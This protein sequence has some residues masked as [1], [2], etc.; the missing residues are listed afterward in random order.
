MPFSLKSLIAC[1]MQA[2]AEHKIQKKE[3][4]KMCF[5]AHINKDGIVQ[6]VAQH[7]GNTARI[8]GNSLRRLGL[9]DSA[10]LAGLLHDAG[11]CTENFREY[12]EKVSRGEDVRRGSVIHTFAAVR[13]L[14]KTYHCPP[15]SEIEARDVTAEILSSAIGG[16]HGLFDCFDGNGIC[17]FIHRINKQPEDDDRAMEGFFREISDRSEVD[18]LFA[19]SI[20]EI[21]SKIR[22]IGSV[23]EKDDEQLFYLSLL[24]RL[25]TS[26]LIDADRSD[27]A[28]F[29]NPD[30]YSEGRCLTP[31]MLKR[32]TEHF[33]SRLSEFECVTPIQTARSELSGLCF[34]AASE[35]GGVLMLNL[36]T[37]AGKTLS[38]L[39]YALRHAEAFGKERIFFIS[40]L[41]SILEQNAL[42]IRKA[43]GDDTI[44]LEHHS[45]IVTGE[46]S[47]DELNRYELLCD[48][49][50]SP[51]VITTL[52]QFLRTLFSGKMSS[53]RRFHSLANSIIV[54]DEVQTVPL[55]MLSLFNSAV[56][57]LSA[58]C[59]ATVILCSA[60]QPYLAAIPHPLAGSGDI[61]RPDVVKKYAPVFKRNT[62][63]YRGK[64][65]LEEIPPLIS[66]LLG[67]YRSVLVVCNK[68]DQASALFDLTE[69][70]CDSRYHLSAGMCAAHRKAVLSE[71]KEMLKPERDDKLLCISTQ[72]I[73]AG[74]DISF[75]AVIRLCAG[76]DSIVQTAGRCNRNGDGRPD[77]PVWIV[78][79]TDE[80]L[81]MLKDIHDAKEAVQSL[82]YFFEKAADR[83]DSDLSS[84][85]SAEFFYKKLYTAKNKDFF[86]FVRK[87][88]PSVYSLLAQN[89]VYTGKDGDK[90]YMHQAFKTAGEL[91]EVFEQE[92]KSVIVPWGD[93]E[94]I[95]GKLL[96][97]GENI[98][99]KLFGAAKPYA[100]SVFSYQFERLSEC[101]AITSVGDGQIWVLDKN[102]YSNNTGIVIPKKGEEICDTLIL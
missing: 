27:T 55:K 75:D 28:S 39:R 100:V 65:L 10:Y 17:G 73:E 54:I 93:G 72:V 97:S 9:S 64:K 66:E 60:T 29:M 42:E 70:L 26:A 30:E 20:E 16:H 13:F 47:G 49:W 68:K 11:K 41:L 99:E 23:S 34:R 2:C 6:T 61:I 37:G 91:F 18:R 36:P 5:P 25:I 51:I 83:F 77:A 89:E 32:V 33:T 85:K 71:M 7:C 12:I 62:I 86:D 80:N 98:S 69:N 56:N 1:N 35:P 52:V 92:Q 48:S 67:Q 15:G 95:A 24:T 19:S 78:D 90:F 31:E 102:Y 59:N 88:Y 44:V 38:G 79:C 57:F 87:G 82:I 53:V 63:T 50:D 84:D 46:L 96:A 76:L 94:A 101:G 43:L 45:D 58:V 74:V 40:P 21:Y 8:A 81:S 22:L 14:L 4:R 3:L